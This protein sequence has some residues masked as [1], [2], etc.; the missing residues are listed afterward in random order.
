MA[1]GDLKVPVCGYASGALDR[2]WEGKAP[3]SPQ[4]GLRAE[5][6]EAS[7]QVRSSAHNPCA[8][9]PSLLLICHHRAASSVR[10]AGAVR[11]CRGIGA[12]GTS[13]LESGGSTSSLC[14]VLAFHS[15]SRLRHSHSSR[16][17]SVSAVLGQANMSD[18]PSDAA[19]AA[20]APASSGGASRSAGAKRRSDALAAKDSAAAD[21]AMSSAADAAAD[22][23]ATPAATTAATAK[24]RKTDGKASAASSSS[25]AADSS[26][27]ALS[28][29]VFYSRTADPALQSLSN[30][31]PSWI[32]MADEEGAPL[33]QPKTGASAAA[34]SAAV[35]ASSH[36]STLRWYPTVEHYFQSCKFLFSNKPALA[37]LFSSAEKGVSPSLGCDPKTAKS[38]GGKGWMARNGATLDVPRWNLHAEA[39]MARALQA[40]FAQPSFA[41]NL[42]STGNRP[43]HHFERQPGLW[44]CNTDKKTGQRRGQ[45]L[46][47]RMLEQIRTKINDE[48]L[49]S[50]AAAAS[51]SPA[52]A[53]RS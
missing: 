29:A 8:S 21:Q 39:V 36:P 51:S 49:N 30:F 19:A 10:V 46:L 7:D 3:C 9:R 14:S 34:T 35:A 13:A 32:A 31:A 26:S 37:M 23:A 12:V 33:A 53:A 41:A 44:G 40:K 22:P 17:S 28:P 20:S 27:T 25:H 42:R 5:R 6:G 16:L 45:N 47:G 38:A 2:A 48:A 18:L 24:R 15:A 50:S 11:R 1:A 52:A 43:L 4:R